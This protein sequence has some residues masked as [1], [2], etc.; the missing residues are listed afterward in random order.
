MNSIATFAKELADRNGSTQ[1]NATLK[2][3]DTELEFPMYMFT[4]LFAIGR[5]PNWIAQWLEMQS[6]PDNRIGR[7]RQIYI[8]ETN[9]KF[10]EVNNR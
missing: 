8:G 9:K 3:D 4:V 1:M 10:I 2:Y 5:L 7:P 6:D